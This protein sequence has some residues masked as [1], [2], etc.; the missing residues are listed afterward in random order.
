MRRVLRVIEDSVAGA[1]I[2]ACLFVMLAF[3]VR[4]LRG[5]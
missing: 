2:A 5:V 1:V 3:L 4:M